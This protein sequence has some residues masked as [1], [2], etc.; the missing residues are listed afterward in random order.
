LGLKLGGDAAEKERQ[1]KSDQKL[2][3]ARRLLKDASEKLEE[4][5]RDRV[6]ERVDKAIKE[7]DVALKVK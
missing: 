5:D 4:A 6:A 7:L 3:E 2:T 1:W